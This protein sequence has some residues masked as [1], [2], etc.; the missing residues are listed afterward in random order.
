MLAACWARALY[1]GLPGPDALPSSLSSAM[2]CDP[3]LTRG[4][5]SSD[6]GDA[7]P[8]CVGSAPVLSRTLPAAVLLWPRVNALRK[9][10]GPDGWMTS[11]LGPAQTHTCV[12][13]TLPPACD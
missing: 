4:E 3:P 7:S 9:L 11:S 5:P 2:P 10:G 13:T 1:V 6:T 8:D 12:K